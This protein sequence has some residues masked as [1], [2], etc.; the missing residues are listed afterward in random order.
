MKATDR[1]S[2]F[3]LMKTA[4]LFS[5]AGLLL[6]GTSVVTFAQVAQSDLSRYLISAR[7][8]L[9]NLA[10][11]T[12]EL[13]GAGEEIWKPLKIIKG[14]SQELQNGDAVKTGENGRLEILLTPGSF[15]RLNENSG[16]EMTDNS[17]DS[18]RL[19]ILNGSAIV[20]ATGVDGVKPDLNIETPQSRVSIVKN[21]IYRI[22][23]SDS[24]AADVFVRKGEARVDLNSSA[25]VD[26]VKIKGGK[27]LLASGFS[28]NNRSNAT[29]NAAPQTDSTG[30]NLTTKFDKKNEDSFDLWS[31]KRAETLVASNSRLT[32]L[33]SSGALTGFFNNSSRYSGRYAPHGLWFYDPSLSCYT[34]SPFYYGWQSPYGFNYPVWYD[35]NTY[36][37]NRF[38]YS[39]HNVNRPATAIVGSPRMPPPSPAANRIY[40]GQHQRAINAGQAVGGGG[41]IRSSAGVGIRSSG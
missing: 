30:K 24:G 22:N 5:I 23:V 37:Y 12:V 35:Y 18:L 13:R 1:S 10:E 4:F 19:K 40:N 33:Y 2:K 9:V 25:Q 11:G 3:L 27:A 34:F 29:T 16:F 15:L 17:L 26:D 36:Y 38:G 31:K 8:G 28:A 32:D 41:H 20:E 39:R 7:A 6:F 14:D 21:G